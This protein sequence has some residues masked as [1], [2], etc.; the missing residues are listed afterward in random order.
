MLQVAEL[1]AF[2]KASGCIVIFISQIA[3]SFDETGE[4]LPTI[5]EVRLPNALDLVAFDRLLFLHDGRR[6]LHVRGAQPSVP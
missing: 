1:R 3:S 5:R 6:R 2:A 4:L